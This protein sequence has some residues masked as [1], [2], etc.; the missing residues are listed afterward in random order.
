MNKCPANLVNYVRNNFPNIKPCYENYLNNYSPPPSYDFCY[1]TPVGNKS[2]IWITTVESKNFCFIIVTN[3]NKTN[4]ND[5]KNL[6]NHNFQIYILPVFFNCTLATQTLIIATKFNISHQT[7]ITFDDIYF[8]KGNNTFNFSF[9]QKLQIFDILLNQEITIKPY[10]HILLGLPIISNNYNQLLQNISNL[11]YKIYAI[12]FK[13]SDSKTIKNI[14]FSQEITYSLPYYQ[15]HITQSRNINN[16]S[17]HSKHVQHVHQSQIKDLFVKPTIDMDTYHAYYNV[18]CLENDSC[19]MLHINNLKSSF[20]MNS[21]FRKVKENSNL[22]L[23]EESDDEDNYQNSY[24]NID[25]NTPIK[26]TCIFNSSFNKW[27][28]LI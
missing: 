22:D 11:Q 18:Q 6:N 24:G 1:A 20:H 5:I 3:N 14:L 26:I 28:P 27:Q 17:N 25:P 9:S 7:F 23:L 13:T 12:K 16:I 19:G 2:Y 21:I 10:K 4:I 8:Y 15:N